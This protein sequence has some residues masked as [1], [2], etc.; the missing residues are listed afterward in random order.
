M[1]ERE[2]MSNRVQGREPD[3]EEMRERERER[4][5]RFWR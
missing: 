4:E 5:D 1:K 3:R 2:N